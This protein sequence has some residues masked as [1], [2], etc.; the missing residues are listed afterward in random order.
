M[1]ACFEIILAR[2]QFYPAR[3]RGARVPEGHSTAQVFLK[4]VGDQLIC[5]KV[6]HRGNKAT[7]Q[8]LDV[9]LWDTSPPFDPYAAEFKD[10]VARWPPGVISCVIAG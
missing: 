1:P 10:R 2:P 6:S 3:H 4:F 7:L 9:D 8:Q 5:D